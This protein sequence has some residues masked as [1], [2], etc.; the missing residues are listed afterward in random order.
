MGRRVVVSSIADID[1][2]I[3]GEIVVDSSL[4]SLGTCAIGKGKRTTLSILLN[5]LMLKKKF[6]L[7]SMR[8]KT[9]E[10]LEMEIFMGKHDAE[11]DQVPS[12]SVDTG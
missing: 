7:D 4:R 12:L 5:Q 3:T 10:K 11:L 1:E 6:D 2:R 8:K 9:R